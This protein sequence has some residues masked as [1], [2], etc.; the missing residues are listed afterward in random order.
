MDLN[1]IFSREFAK[2]QETGLKMYLIQ[3]CQLLRKVLKDS[4][5][6][7]I[8]GQVLNRTVFRCVVERYP[9]TAHM[10]KW[11]YLSRSFSRRDRLR[12]MINHYRFIDKYFLPNFMISIMEGEILLWE[13]VKDANRYSISLVHD[14]HCSE[15]DLSLIYK[16]NGELVYTLAFAIIPG[17]IVNMRAVQVLFISRI[18][19]GF[20]RYDL[21][22]SSIKAF[23]GIRPATMLLAVAR[24][25][26]TA[27]G[28]TCIAGV[29]TKHQLA[30]HSKMDTLQ[31]GVFNYDQF[32]TEIGGQGPNN[33]QVFSVPITP[34]HIPLC[35]RKREH[36][37]RKMQQY[38]FESNLIREI[39]DTFG[40]RCLK[41]RNRELGEGTR[42]NVEALSVLGEC[43]G[44]IGAIV[45]TMKDMAKNNKLC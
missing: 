17:R 34:H 14:I 39:Q 9:D 8:V 18:Q 38:Q 13:E 28:I 12:S 29:R 37:T 45:T 32:W 4:V 10:Y 3:R 20:D 35:D 31:G 43:S 24:A 23:G 33:S 22:R 15:G 16:L 27:S 36:R 44:L 25:I 40:Q 2:C 21:I 26:A 7:F 1:R 41:F 6:T 30:L 11:Q 5:E 42:K 19:G